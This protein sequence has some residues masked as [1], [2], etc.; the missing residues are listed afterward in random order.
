METDSL[1]IGIF[2][3]FPNIDDFSIVATEVEDKDGKISIKPS[4]V[5]TEN[6]IRIV[7]NTLIKTN[8]DNYTFGLLKKYGL[9]EKIEKRSRVPKMREVLNH[10]AVGELENLVDDFLFNNKFLFPEKYNNEKDI[11]TISKKLDYNK[12][13]GLNP[14]FFVKALCDDKDKTKENLGALKEY[15]LAVL[16]LK[17][18]LVLDNPENNVNIIFASW[19]VAFVNSLAYFIMFLMPFLKKHNYFPIEYPKDVSW[20]KSLTSTEDYRDEEITKLTGKIATLLSFK[21]ENF[22][23]IDGLSPISEE[24]SVFI[25]FKNN[26]FH[27][28]QYPKVHATIGNIGI[29]INKKMIKYLETG[30]KDKDTN[31]TF[32]V[33]NVRMY[34]KNLKSLGFTFD[35]EMHLFSLLTLCSNNPD[36]MEILIDLG[37]NP[38]YF[39]HSNT[40]LHHMLSDSIRVQGLKPPVKSFRVLLKKRADVNLKN[41][42][43]RTPLHLVFEEGN[44]KTY[45]Y[46][47]LNDIM[48]LFIEC[49]A[50]VNSLDN[51]G[52]APLNIIIS[53]KIT[54]FEEK[55]NFIEYIIEYGADV[56]IKYENDIT[57]FQMIFYNDFPIDE[58]ISLINLFLEA[59]AD[60]NTQNKYQE[61]PL[62]V[63]F[64]RRIPLKEKIILIEFLLNAGAYTDAQDISRKT[65]LHLIINESGYTPKD[66]KILITLFIE[67]G[68][69]INIQDKYGNTPLHLLLINEFIPENKDLI[70]LFIENG[71]DLFIENYKGET[72]KSL[73]ESM[74]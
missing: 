32:S 54:P 24:D 16:F 3:K 19:T 27:G 23:I 33:E 15:Q 70:N 46:K 13:F 50:D 73:C 62:H 67:N 58:K 64:K 39:T 6:I 71:A 22:Y 11:L 9:D 8:L 55:Y 65:I 29:G 40:A 5:V 53:N 1:P 36:L 21:F 68:A 34:L 37:A 43:G 12:T 48:K 44:E 18:V 59:G 35:K 47:E 10:Y 42:S 20:E 14:Y 26:M 61:T 69:D 49:G 63:I 60:I 57:P 41:G 25:S 56:N 66:K 7:Y 72:P 31:Q 45:S 74:K 38:N 28:Y 52:Y 4:R 2:S 17:Y 51:S 30:K